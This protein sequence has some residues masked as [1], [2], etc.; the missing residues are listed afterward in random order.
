[1]VKGKSVS[2]IVN[3]YDPA[4]L[5]TPGRGTDIEITVANQCHLHVTKL[6]TGQQGFKLEVTEPELLGLKSFDDK[7]TNEFMRRV[8]LACNL[9]LKKAAFST[10][11]IDSLH[12]GVVLKSPQ[13]T[14]KVKKTPTGS[15]ITITEVVSLRDSLSLTVGFSDELDEKKVIDILQKI[16]AVFDYGGSPPLEILNMQKSLDA[17]LRGIQATDASHVFKGLYEAMELAVNFDRS[18]R[19]DKDFDMEVRRIMGDSTISIGVFRRFNNRTKHPDNNEQH[20][21]YETGK[22]NIDRYICT[23]RPITTTTILC[24]L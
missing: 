12:A 19:K 17:Y 5:P 14:S 22:A 16:H 15:K 10:S 7:H 1:M 11:S 20:K 18:D 21:V 6:D 8:I 9:I 23:L 2:K 13:S 4:Q 3:A 24:R